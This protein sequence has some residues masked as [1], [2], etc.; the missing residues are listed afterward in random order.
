MN[1]TIL[2]LMK[3]LGLVGLIFTVGCKKDDNGSSLKVGM[4]YEGGIIAYVDGSGEHG[5][6]AAPSDHDGVYFWGKA[7]TVCE[8]LIIDGYDDWYF[9]SKEELN[10]L[11]NNKDDIGGFIEDVY[12]SSTELENNGNGAW[13]QNFRDG[14]Q[15]SAAKTSERKVRSVRTF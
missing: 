13:A 10:T 12:W 4:K 1:K 5:L 6:I 8:E 15:G 2:N 11:Y 14:K 9:P 3:V 7:F